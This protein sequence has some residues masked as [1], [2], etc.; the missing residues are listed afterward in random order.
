MNTY[1]IGD[2]F[3]SQKKKK[4]EDKELSLSLENE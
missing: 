4:K 2:F 3:F 1:Q